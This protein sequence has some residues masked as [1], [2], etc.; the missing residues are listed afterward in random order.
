MPK[1]LTVKFVSNMWSPGLICKLSQITTFKFYYNACHKLNE[2]YTVKELIK[3]PII[4]KYILF[5]EAMII[6]FWETGNGVFY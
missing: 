5:N 1:S 4:K 6:H 3:F 2:I